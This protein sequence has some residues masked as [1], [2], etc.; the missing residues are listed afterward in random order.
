MVFL[1]FGSHEMTAL[2]RERHEFRPGDTLHLKPRTDVVHLF[3][4]ATGK[5]L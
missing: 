3:D 4:A 2:F 5:R 1:R